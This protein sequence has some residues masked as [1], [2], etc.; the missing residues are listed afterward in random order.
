MLPLR[1]GFRPGFIL[2][3]QACCTTDS[4]ISVQVRWEHDLHFLVCTEVH[5]TEKYT[6]WK[7]GVQ[8]PLQILL[9]PRLYHSKV[10]STQPSYFSQKPRSTHFQPLYQSL[11]TTPCA[12]LQVVSSC[13]P[14]ECEKQQRL[15]DTSIFAWYQTPPPPPSLFLFPRANVVK[16]NEERRLGF[17]SS[18]PQV[19]FAVEKKKR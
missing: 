3:W 15:N 17:S 1:D 2:V 16:A 5:R 19:G 13:P 8:S 12:R 6:V 10:S 11:P 14:V 18:D 4:A 7:Y 9:T